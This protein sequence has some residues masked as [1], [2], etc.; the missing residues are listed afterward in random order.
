MRAG[1]I[2][3]VV[4]RAVIVGVIA[5]GAWAAATMV[6]HAEHGWE[7]GPQDGPTVEQPVVRPR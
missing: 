6:A 5:L 1:K 4:V 3:R 2:G 7:V